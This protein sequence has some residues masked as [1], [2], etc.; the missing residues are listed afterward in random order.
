MFHRRQFLTTALASG[1]AAPALL[2]ATRPAAAVEAAPILAPRRVGIS[3]A[4]AAGSIVI[5]PRAYFLYHVTAP[6]EAMR[7]GIAVARPG[8]GFTGKAVIGRKVEWPSWRPTPDM[9][10]RDPNIYGKYAG[11]SDRMP[12]GPRNPLGARALYLYQDGRDTAI[13]IHGTTEPRSIGRNASSGCFRMLNENVIALYEQVP[14][15]TPVT[16]L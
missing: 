8:L 14:I 7:Y 9:I 2:A 1:L 4:H 15:G 12:G 5:L 6:G 13:R 11:N 3:K 10:A 16:V